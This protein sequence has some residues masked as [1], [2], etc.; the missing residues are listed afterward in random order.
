MTAQPDSVAPNGSGRYVLT[1]TTGEM[2]NGGDITIT[3]TNVAD[4]AGNLIGNQNTATAAKAGRDGLITVNIPARRDVTLFEDNDGALANG[5]GTTFFVGNNSDNLRRRGVLHFDVV[6]NIPQGS[7]IF[8][9][10]LKLTQAGNVGNATAQ[11][12]TVHTVGAEWFEGDVDAGDPGVDGAPSE[13]GEAT[14]IHREFDATLWTT[15]G[16]D[17][18]PTAHATTSV[19][20]PG[21]YSWA[22][23]LLDTD[24]QTWLDDGD[25]NFGWLILGDE[26]QADTVKGFRSDEH[27]PL[28]ER[29]RL[30]VVF[31]LNGGSGGPT[32]GSIG[33]QT[34]EEGETL[35]LS[36]TANDTDNN[37]LAI[38]APFANLPLENNAVLTDNGD[39]TAS[40]SWT[41]GFLDGGNYVLTFIATQ[42]GPADPLSISESIVITVTELNQVPVLEAFAPATATEGQPF[43]V[44]AIAEDNDVDDVLTYS[45][46][47]PVAGVSID[48]AS[49][50][51]IWTP[52]F[53]D[54]GDFQIAVRVTDNGSPPRSGQETLSITVQDAN[55]PPSIVTP[56][57]Q[58]VVE[59]EV[60]SFKIEATD[61]DL[62]DVLT[63]S[64]ENSPTGST[65][66]PATGVFRWTPNIAAAGDHEATVRVTDDGDPAMSTSVTFQIAVIDD[67]RDPTAIALSPSSVGENTA[68]DTLVGTLTTTDP[69][70]GDTH[71]YTLISGTGDTGNSQFVIVGTELRSN[72]TFDFETRSSYSIR[73]NSFDGKDGSIQMPLTISIVDG[74]DLPTALGLSNTD[75]MENTAQGTVVGV[76]T[77]TDQ[78]VA[79]QHTYTLVSGEGDADN[80]IFAISGR[81]LVVNGAIDFEMQTALSIRI[82][83]E[84]RGGAFV[85][86]SFVLTVSNENDLADGVTLSATQVSENAPTATEV[87]RFMTNDDDG[88]SQSYRLVSGEGSTNNTDFRIV[89]DVLQTARVLDFE[90]GRMRSIRVR[91][92]DAEQSA[93]EMNFL[94]EVLD[95]NDPPTDLAINAGG[96]LG[97]VP[98]DTVIGDLVT[99][100]QDLEDSHTYALVA[101]EGDTNNTRFRIEERQLVAA[102][103][104]DFNS[105]DSFS[106]RL[107]T[108]D[109]A[110]ATFEKSFV[111]ENDDTDSDGLSDIWELLHFGNLM[112][113]ADGDSD[114]DGL[115]NIE[116]FRLGTI[117]TLGDSDGDG[118]LDGDEVANGTNPTN[119]ADAPAILNVSPTAATRGREESTVT[120]QVRNTGLAVLN[121]QAE[122]VSGDFAQIVSGP[123]GQN[124]GEVAVLLSSN[125]SSSARNATV[126]ITA[127][128]TV[129]SPV[130]VVITQSAC[131]APNVPSDVFA[132]N[133][134]LPGQVRVLWD[135]VAEAEQYMVFRSLGDDPNAADLIATVVGTAFTDTTAPFLDDTKQTTDAG[136]GCLPILGPGPTPSTN[137]YQ[138]W[139]RAMNVCGTSGF[140]NPDDGFPGA[141]T[142]PEM[143]LFEP[144]LPG[145]ETDTRALRVRADS[146]LAIRLSQDSAIDPGTIRGEVARDSGIDT[147]VTWRAIDT[148]GLRDGWVVYNPGENPFEEGEAIIFTVTASTV[149]GESIGPLTYRFTVET[150]AELLDRIGAGAEAVFQPA[151]PDFDATGI[152]QNLENQSEITVYALT[153]VPAVLANA[154]GPAYAFVPDELFD[155]RQRV[156]LPLAEGQRIDDVVVN[157]YFSDKTG[158]RSG[159]YP[160]DQIVGWSNMSTYLELELDGVRYIGFTARHGALVQLS[161]MSAKDISVSAAGSMPTMLERVGGDGIVL[162]L[163]LF[164]MVIVVPRLKMRRPSS[165]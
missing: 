103:A 73:V 119:S 13:D 108:R 86:S 95:T 159:W 121:W 82:R 30:Q 12:Y 48:S 71:T 157:Y 143:A 98:Q 16:G 58:T 43:S 33:D 140:S 26:S 18:D 133:G 160:A 104:I 68:T 153:E 70:G 49:G 80:G 1:W 2:L 128:G 39:G 66:D 147:A 105:V 54:A 93:F 47:V 56:G 46:V 150:E 4:A 161:A 110:G 85:E 99:T 92:I 21:D 100:D 88:G 55:G 6:G 123:S 23:D 124:A 102:Q 139:V 41:P 97:N 3:A 76:L 29:P 40:F 152:D 165:S 36:L 94:I 31:S 19:T 126:R 32:L 113:A 24:V 42:V 116:E 83:S 155:I 78:D 38:S 145:F 114:G 141:G 101:G 129:G 11:D 22:D 34:V 118:V 136:G 90:M 122:V 59:A 84:D 81:N 9:S 163:L 15:P 61:P 148:V 138:Y 45:L 142:P 25:N 154:T 109:E 135:G 112:M 89:D 137:A 134:S 63:Y 50:E 111:L 164:G 74:N 144:V 60:L 79:D 91:S 67:N 132:T 130:D 96:I 35:T 20:G 7:I 87:G 151:Y 44:T 77:T 53:S 14:W 162:M 75:V 72:A 64:L 131:S 149:A 125:G 120:I 117:P 57:P 62:D 52:G 5:A 10:T 27:G 156:W 8:D 115:T 51:L 65:I 17:F 146:V 158:A 106:V 107:Q 37:P 69:D 127:A 28:A